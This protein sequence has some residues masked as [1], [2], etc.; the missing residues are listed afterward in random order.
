MADILAQFTPNMVV[1]SVLDIPLDHLERAGIRGLLF[2]LDNTL[3]PHYDDAFSPDVISWLEHLAARGLSV[4]MVTNAPSH[5]ALPLAEVLNMRC[6]HRARKPLGSGV[7]AGVSM[8]A[9]PSAQVAMVGD[10]LFTDVWA[11]RRASTYTI[12][13]HQE[14]LQEPLHIML[15]RPIEQ[16]LTRLVKL[17]DTVDTVSGQSDFSG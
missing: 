17:P 12:W 14:D 4:A 16:I 5:R 7:R 11:G 1:N 15:K 13:V 6:I 9:L 10:Q 3:I 2:D 8:L